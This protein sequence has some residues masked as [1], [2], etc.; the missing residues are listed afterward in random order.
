MTE[1]TKMFI[2]GITIAVIGL[3]IFLNLKGK[4]DINKPNETPPLQIP[5]NLLQ[6]DMKERQLKAA[7][8]QSPENRDILFRLGSLYFESNRYN[9]AIEI[10]KRILKIKSDDVETLT[11]LGLALH[12]THNSQE[13]IKYLKKATSLS[14]DHQR[15][16]LSLGF[17][18]GASGDK[19]LAERALK[20]AISIGAD[21][22][23][24]KEASRILNLL[25]NQ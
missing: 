17:V 5:Q 7:L 19:E 9:E 2:L 4:E 1:R 12:Y 10:Y 18:S 24:G 6:T 25:K 14:P 20:K 22:P 8:E 16:W 23:M 11:D 15:A 3:V 21:T 13:G